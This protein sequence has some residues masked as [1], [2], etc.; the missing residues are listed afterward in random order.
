MMKEIGIEME[1][2]RSEPT[3]V[4]LNSKWEDRCTVKS[5]RAGLAP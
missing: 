2:G 4:G 5:N 3:E 1:M